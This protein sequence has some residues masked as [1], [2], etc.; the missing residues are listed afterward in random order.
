MLGVDWYDVYLDREQFASLL[1]DIGVSVQQ[2]PNPQSPQSLL[3]DV[4]GN[5]KT[6]RTGAAGRPTSMHLVLKIA[7][8]RLDAGDYPETKT[9]FSEQLAAELKTTHPEAAPVKPKTM[10]S[11]LAL[12]EL[13]R[14]RSNRPK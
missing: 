13:W 9:A 1:R 10:R 12:S 4:S 5:E 2:N 14:R 11:N 7:K 3:D 8:R 6:Y